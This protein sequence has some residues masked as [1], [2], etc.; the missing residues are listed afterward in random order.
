MRVSFKLVSVGNLCKRYAYRQDDADGRY[1]NEQGIV[2]PVTAKLI[3][4]SVRRRLR[5][6]TERWNLSG[7]SAPRMEWVM[8]ATMN[9]WEKDRRL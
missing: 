9:M 8:S 7:K 1:Y 5:M 6:L 4:L 3:E 2:L